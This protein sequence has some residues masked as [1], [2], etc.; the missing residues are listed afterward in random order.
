MLLSGLGAASPTPDGV[1]AKRAG[2]QLYE[3]PICV[4]GSFI[5]GGR[6]FSIADKDISAMVENFEKRKNDMVVI[7]YEHASEDPAVA[8]GGP[9]PAAGWIHALTANGR[10]MALVE[11]TLESEQM[12]RSGQYRFFSPAIDWSAKDK[13]TGEPQGATLTSGALTNHPFLEE[14]PPIMLSDG[15]V[16][17]GHIADVIHQGTIESVAKTAY[18]NLASGK[19]TRRELKQKISNGHLDKDVANAYHLALHVHEKH[20]DDKEAA[21]AAISSAAKAGGHFVTID[22]E[23][24]FIANSEKTPTSDKRGAAIMAD[25]EKDKN[26]GDEGGHELPMLK[27]RKGRKGSKQDG[28][29]VLSTTGEGGDDVGYLSDDDLKQHA[30]QHLGFNPDADAAKAQASELSRRATLF[31]E[32]VKDGKVNSQAAI[33]MSEQGKITFA[34]YILATEAEKQIDAAIRAGKILPRNRAFFFRDAIERPEE[35]AEYVTSAAPVVMLGSAGIGGAR[36]AS[37][38]DAIR[39]G[40]KKLMAENSKLSHAQAHKQFLSEN[41]D[42]KREYELAHTQRSVVDADGVSVH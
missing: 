40:V 24:V 4:T 5:K 35:F 36:P 26:K 14:L 16:L 27:I 31:S 19:R 22:D 34:D 20:G 1:I 42:L 23:P 21:H 28:H 41:P 37:P 3:I 15:S 29:H 18:N 6:D 33:K 7:D 2:A 17:F 8:H 30:A 9:V 32:V 25:E 38:D 13:N 11:W 12:I 39:L 10:L